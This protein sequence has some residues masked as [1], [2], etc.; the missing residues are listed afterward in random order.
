MLVVVAI[1]A[2]HAFQTFYSDRFFLSL[3]PAKAIVRDHATQSAAR[4]PPDAQA[5]LSRF[6]Q[7]VAAVGAT[8]KLDSF[9]K[10]AN[11]SERKG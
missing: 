3:S 1:A 7:K 2:E 11:L 10:K 9:F 4:A 6:F 8:N 5:K